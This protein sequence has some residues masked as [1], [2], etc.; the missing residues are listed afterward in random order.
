MIAANYG[1]KS[2]QIRAQN[3]SSSVPNHST[4]SIPINNIDSYHLKRY[5]L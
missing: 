4:K 5:C 3:L 2:Q 1:I